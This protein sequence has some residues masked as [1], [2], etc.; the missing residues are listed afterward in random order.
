M[1]KL[2]QYHY[3]PFTQDEIQKGNKMLVVLQAVGNEY[4]INHVDIKF[5]AYS[6]KKKK[7]AVWAALDK[8]D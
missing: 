8:I 4:K 5:K 1:T 3:L 2:L 6:R 7:N